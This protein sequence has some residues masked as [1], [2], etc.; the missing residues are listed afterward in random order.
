MQAYLQIFFRTF[1]ASQK[2]QFFIFSKKEQEKVKINSSTYP[3]F[4]PTAHKCLFIN[5]QHKKSP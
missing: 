3:C 2:F 5:T 4:F 1:Y